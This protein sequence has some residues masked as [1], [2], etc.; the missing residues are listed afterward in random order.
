LSRGSVGFYISRL[1]GEGVLL[2]SSRS[3]I[4]QIVNKNQKNI[5]PSEREIVLTEPFNIIHPHFHSVG[6]TMICAPV[7]HQDQAAESL[8]ALAYAPEKHRYHTLS[9]EMTDL[10]PV[11]TN[12]LS[13]QCMGTK[14]ITRC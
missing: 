9:N 4:R 11:T 12:L 5:I 6:V 7:T 14:L 8:T 13:A 3:P 2:R 1:I 10:R